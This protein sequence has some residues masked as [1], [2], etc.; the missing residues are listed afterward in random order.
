MS[1]IPPRRSVRPVR[2]P[3]GPNGKLAL[4]RFAMSGSGDSMAGT[5]A[6]ASGAV[7][8]PTDRGELQKAPA[9]EDA[10]Q[11]NPYLSADVAGQSWR[12]KAN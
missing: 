7:M 10:T 6:T 3:T 4:T 9:G 1:R 8:K 5:V 11:K 2:T 12:K